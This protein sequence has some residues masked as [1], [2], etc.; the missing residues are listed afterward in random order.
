M[1]FYNEENGEVSQIA[2]PVG[3]SVVSDGLVLHLDAGETTSYSGTG[4]TWTD[5]SGNGNNGTLI[6]GVGF[7]SDNG[8]SLDFTGSGDYVLV[9]NSPSLQQSGDTSFQFTHYPQTLG[10]TR[11]SI[12]DKSNQEF[13]ITW[14]PG[15]KMNFYSYGGVTTILANEYAPQ[16]NKWFDVTIVRDLTNARIKYYINGVLTKTDPSPDAWGVAIPSS[17]QVTSNNI[18]IGDGYLTD[19]YG[20]ISRFMMYGKALSDAEVLQNFEAVKDRYGL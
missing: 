7:N 8:G 2:E 3:P 12:A 10:S 6:N 17:A 19:Y 14:E 11:R 20:R 5:L 16:A 4:T 18:K 15:G 9:N 13:Q 1:F